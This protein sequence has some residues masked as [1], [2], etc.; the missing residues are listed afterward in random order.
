MASREVVINECDLGCGKTD[1]EVVITT[2]TI[3]VDGVGYEFEA[4]DVDWD[5][6]ILRAVATIAKAGRPVKQKRARKQ[7][8][9]HSGETVYVFP[10]NGDW[11]FTAHALQRMGERKMDPVK[12]IEAVENPTNTTP[13]F[14]NTDAV[15]FWRRGIK[16]VANPTQARIVTVANRHEDF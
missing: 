15:V 10:D 5:K 6:K 16:V 14:D 7:Q 9:A 3:V 4:C 13:G 1:Q 12:V 2:H 8:P 11:Q